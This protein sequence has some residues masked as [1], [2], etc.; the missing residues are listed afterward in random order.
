MTTTANV[1]LSPKGNFKIHYY[2]MLPHI[3]T[4]FEIW[5]SLTRRCN[6][7]CVLTWSRDRT[8]QCTGKCGLGSR[9][10]YYKCSRKVIENSNFKYV[11]I[12]NDT[13]SIQ[14]LIHNIQ[15]T[16]F[17]KIEDWRSRQL[18]ND[19]EI[20]AQKWL[21]PNGRHVQSRVEAEHEPGDT[22]A[23]PKLVICRVLNHS[24]PTATLL[25]VQC[26]QLGRGPNVP[27]HVAVGH[28][29]IL[30]RRKQKRQMVEDVKERL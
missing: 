3:R 6:Q 29:S 30:E 8:T 17:A 11:D 22:S 19:A 27:K 1:A 20:G 7:D 25:P 15:Q 24:A 9:R 2:S 21:I 18:S 16:N 13:Y 28:E 5:K 23:L 26:G 14:L 12:G 10:I 4:N